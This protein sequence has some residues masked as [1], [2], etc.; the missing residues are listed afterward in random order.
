M[1]AG[2]ISIIIPTLNEGATLGHTLDGIGIPGIGSP[3]ID[4]PGTD[5]PGTS[6][7]GIDAPGTDT[8]GTDTPGTDTLG[9]EVIVA[10]GGSTDDTYAV[11]QARG[12]QVVVATGGRGVQLNRGADLAQGDILLFLHADT[13]LPPDFATLVRQTLAQP[14]VVAGA[15][16]LAIDG[17][18]WGLRWVE[19]GVKWR[20]RWL[21]L[22]YGDQAIFLSAQ[23]F[24]QMGGFA[25]L[26]IMEDFNLVQRLSRQGRIAMV[27]TPV[28]TSSR[29]WQRLGVGQTTLANQGMVIGY[30]LGLDI[31]QLARWY[32]RLGRSGRPV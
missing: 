3:E 27:P 24:R 29:R 17:P 16:D 18:G 30:M 21:S 9:I 12:V 6:T 15:F 5:T 26:P 1:A 32:R 10:D 22:P 14:G 13:R 4:T 11:A 2:L 28:T 7:P 20:S 31:D 25:P 19:W 8:S 23:R